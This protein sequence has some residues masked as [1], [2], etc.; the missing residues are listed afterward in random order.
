MWP[1]FLS[2]S[3]H[4]PIVLI[5][6][7]QFTTQ[8]FFW[9]KI[10]LTVL[11]GNAIKKN[12]WNWRIFLVNFIWLAEC[13]SIG[14][15]WLIDSENIEGISMKNISMMSFWGPS[16]EFLVSNLVSI[17]V[18]FEFVKWVTEMNEK[19]AFISNDF[20]ILLKNQ[21]NE[22]HETTSKH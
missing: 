12:R 17:F 16:G 18:I 13:F 4:T 7:F 2:V 21:M 19:G 3:T 22:N 1:S 5:L 11:S 20:S 8:H 9:M 15:R 6:S 14:F 10:S